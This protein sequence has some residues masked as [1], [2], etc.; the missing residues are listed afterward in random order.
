MVGAK[1]QNSNVKTS[2]NALPPQN[3]TLNLELKSN[4]LTLKKLKLMFT[5]VKIAIKIIPMT[6][7]ANCR[8]STRTME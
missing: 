5:P 4:R 7:L 1:L 3:K 6:G 8:T 2:I